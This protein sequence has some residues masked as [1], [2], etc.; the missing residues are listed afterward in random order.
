M[1]MEVS[2]AAFHAQAGI[3]YFAEAEV[4]LHPENNPA[5]SRSR[6]SLSTGRE[7]R[8]VRMWSD[9]GPDGVVPSPA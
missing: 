3:E 4:A 7:S 5:A 1:D 6:V 8:T 2:G 9:C